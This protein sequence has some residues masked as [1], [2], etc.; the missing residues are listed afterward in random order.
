MFNANMAY[1]DDQART[2]P[3]L[4][5]TLPQLNTDAWRVFPDGHMEVTYHLR[6]NI[7]WHD[8]T[9]F[10]AEDFVFSYKA[11]ST[12]AFGQASLSP[13]RFIEDVSAPD[14][15]TVM[16]RF[17]QPYPDVTFVAGLNA[18]FPPLPRHILEPLVG[19]DQVD[20]FTN[21]LYWTREY[22]GLGPYKLDRW[23]PGTFLEGVAFDQHILGRPKIDRIRLQFMPDARAVLA[24]VLAGEIHL[25]DGTS[26]G[27]P[28]MTVLKREWVAKGLG[29]IE[30]HPNQWRAIHF[31]HRPD[32]L[33]PPALANPTIRKALAHGVDRQALNEALDVGD[34]VASDSPFAPQS[35]WGAAAQRGAVAY[36]YDPRRADQLMQEAGY[37]K[38]ADGF[39]ASPAA[40]RFTVEVKTNAATDNE[41]EVSILASTW[42]QAGFDVQEAILPAAQA[43]NAEARSTF[44]GMYTNS[45]NCCE[46]AMLG[47][48][49][50][51]APSAENRWSGGNRSGYANPEYDALIDSFTRT[52]DRGERETQMTQLVRLLTEDVQSITMFIRAQGWAHVSEL[53]GVVVAP[54]EG[55]MSWNIDKWEFR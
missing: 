41:S 26:A 38:G 44:S 32:Y 28:E 9:P 46:S 5:E 40:G 49:S 24:S 3:Y 42:R 21:S 4:I 22:V 34:G 12:P 15:R 20:A 51:G 23:E 55:N 14:P 54:P 16:I 6:P 35:I 10:T 2:N 13:I 11:Y 53:R 29:S 36:P 7:V 50:S 19:S 17:R 25:T 8:G 1:L 31:Q 37:A 45:Q 43:Q 48:V 52:L 30:L 47:L 27:L 39:F 18:E 33:S